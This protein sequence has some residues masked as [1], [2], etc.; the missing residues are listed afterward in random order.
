[1][2][3]GLIGASRRLGFGLSVILAAGF[4]LV[5]AWLTPRGPITDTPD[6]Y[7]QGKLL[8]DVAR[9]A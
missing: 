3:I 4:A 2:V 8:D 9:R 5:S 1:V 7:I 6:L